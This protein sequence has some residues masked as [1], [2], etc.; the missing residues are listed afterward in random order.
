MNVV[1]NAPEWSKRKRCLSR[2]RRG[3]PIGLRSKKQCLGTTCGFSNGAVLSRNVSLASEADL[4][5]K[6]GLAHQGE[7]SAPHTQPRVPLPPPVAPSQ[8]PLSR[9]P[10][11]PQ[12]S[13]IPLNSA[14]GTRPGAHTMWAMLYISWAVAVIWGSGQ[15]CA[16]S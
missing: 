8:A 4:G 10:P 14:D 11:Q 5:R 6:F 9:S 7:C 12:P 13:T 2:A 1:L 3:R 15:F 16:V